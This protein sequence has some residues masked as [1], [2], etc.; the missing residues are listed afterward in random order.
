MFMRREQT[1]VSPEQALPGREN[2]AFSIP[3]RHSVLDTPLQPP[4]PEGIE[5][6]VFALGCF[7]GA[8]RGIIGVLQV[9]E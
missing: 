6:A 2:A 7:W 9:T 4:F 3:A 8:E 1:I 5:T